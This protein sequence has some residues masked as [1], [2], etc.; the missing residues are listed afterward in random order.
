MKIGFE[1][2]KKKIEGFLVSGFEINSMFNIHNS[3]FCKKKRPP[4]T[5][6]LY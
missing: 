4:E 6:S 5:D 3:I 1:K 2:K